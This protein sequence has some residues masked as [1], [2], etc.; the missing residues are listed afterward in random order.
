LLHL[1]L[2]LRR[3]TN[4]HDWI[5]ELKHYK[6]FPSA[7]T[8][9]FFQRRI[10]WIHMK[11]NWMPM[12]TFIHVALSWVVSIDNL[13]THNWTNISNL[14]YF[15]L[16]YIANLLN[17]MYWMERYFFLE[18]SAFHRAHRGLSNFTGYWP[19]ECPVTASKSFVYEVNDLCKFLRIYL[20]K[21][22]SITN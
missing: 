9:R 18:K 19:S 10:H 14:I 2:L 8:E 3:W 17:L 4:K 5:H 12:E 20:P 11:L 22:L 16:R 7:S 21:S 6:D 15:S 13:K 1:S